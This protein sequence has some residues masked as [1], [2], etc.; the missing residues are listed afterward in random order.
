MYLKKI[1]MDK[2][3][4]DHLDFLAQSTPGKSGADIANICNEA[5]LN[6]ARES[7]DTVKASCWC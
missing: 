4:T 1:S 5:A 3:I 6:A 2:P 7:S